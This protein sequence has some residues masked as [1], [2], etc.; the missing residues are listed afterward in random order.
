MVSSMG[1]RN[2]TKLPFTSTCALVSL[3]IDSMTNG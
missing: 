1:T 3:V 2:S